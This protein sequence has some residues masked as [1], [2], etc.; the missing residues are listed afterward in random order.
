MIPV[1]KDIIH[2]G[3]DLLRAVCL[4]HIPLFIKFDDQ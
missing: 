1:N 2:K 4:I 3:W